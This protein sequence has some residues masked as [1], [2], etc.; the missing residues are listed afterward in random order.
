MKINWWLKINR[1]LGISLL[2]ILPIVA[3]FL[4]QNQSGEKAIW[5]V[6]IGMIFLIST[7]IIALVENINES[8]RSLLQHT[9]KTISDKFGRVK[10]KQQVGEDEKDSLQSSLSS[11][12]SKPL[13]LSNNGSMKRKE[14]EKK[15]VNKFETYDLRINQRIRNEIRKIKERKDTDAEELALRRFATQLETKKYGETDWVWRFRN[16]FRPRSELLQ[17]L[18]D[19][20]HE[21]IEELEN[22]K[23][24]KKEKIVKPVV[25]L[26]GDDDPA[27][28]DANSPPETSSD[29][30][31]PSPPSTSHPSDT[32]NSLQSPASPLL[33][34]TEPIPTIILPLPPLS[35][36]NTQRA[37][38][39]KNNPKPPKSKSDLV[40]PA[41]STERGVLNV[42]D[43]TNSPE[44]PS[45]DEFRPDE[46]IE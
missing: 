24:N 30:M 35:P 3:F 36:R 25:N 23:Q 29:G 34:E 2:F 15:K 37:R 22:D 28:N 12:P 13:S 27:S 7:L 38:A 18:L 42:P 40:K 31:P 4:L 1:W 17:K 44:L 14:K 33:Q 16:F 39:L 6:A 8:M 5:N 20:I 19:D 41:E 32:D 10:R 21:Q 45:G 43:Q 11:S 26:P 46:S 9:L